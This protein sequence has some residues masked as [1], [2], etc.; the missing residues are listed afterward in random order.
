MNRI[1]LKTQ[2]SS[3]WLS[4]LPAEQVFAHHLHQLDGTF[5][6]RGLVGEFASLQDAFRII[7]PAEADRSQGDGPL[8]ALANTVLIAAQMAGMSAVVRR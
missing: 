6:A 1:H 5:R 8:L 4:H 7:V 3:P 2:S